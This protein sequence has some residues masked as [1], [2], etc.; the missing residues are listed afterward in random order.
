MYRDLEPRCRWG[1]R[2][3]RTS[4]ALHAG[5]APAMWNRRRRLARVL[6]TVG[7]IWKNLEQLD[8][9]SV[10]PAP[11][12]RRVADTNPAVVEF[13]Y[14]GVDFGRGRMSLASQNVPNPGVRIVISGNT[15]MSSLPTAARDTCHRRAGRDRPTPKTCLPTLDPPAFR[16]APRVGGA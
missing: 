5:R 9:S 1:K 13:Q 8:D 10:R 6:A 3:T 2:R 15:K 12:H 14:F 7:K 4:V 11:G 16:S